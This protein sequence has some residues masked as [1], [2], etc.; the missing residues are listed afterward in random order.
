MLVLGGALLFAVAGRP[1]TATRPVLVAAVDL[2]PGDVVADNDL[3]V[4]DIASDGAFSSV[5]AAERSSLVGRR[6]RTSVAK[7]TVVYA[8]LFASGASVPDGQVVVGAALTAGELP[9]ATLQPGDR[10]RVLDVADSGG[11]VV[12]EAVVFDVRPLAS[13][14]GQFVSLRVA[15]ADGAAVAEAAAGGRLRL[16]LAGSSG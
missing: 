9:V 16:L 15:A 11:G 3:R 5:A 8:G 2:A 14:G 12:A 13:Q 6:A 10:V 1:S 4:V 7:G